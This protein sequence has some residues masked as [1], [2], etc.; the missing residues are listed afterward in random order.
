MIDIRA[1]QQQLGDLLG[2]LNGAPKGLATA[3]SR[4]GNKTLTSTRAEMVRLIRAKYAIKA[5]DI[6]RELEIR[7]M[8]PSKLEGRIYG[9][10]SPGVPLIRFYRLRRTPSTVRTKAG[11]YSPKIGVPV[12]VRKDKGKRTVRGAFTARMKSGHE[13]MFVRGSRWK[14]SK[15][16]NRSKL[17]KREI[18]ELYGPTPIKLLGGNE[19][20]AQVEAF[21][22]T[23]MD[24]NLAHEADYFLRQQG[25]R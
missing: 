20:I 12:L 15:R 22:Q 2:L 6:R 13:G 8:N 1:N 17:G 24:K 10:S 5:G 21:A 3:T 25:L 7:R 9:E 18:T 19:N 14:T 4:A 11:G 16:G 23:S